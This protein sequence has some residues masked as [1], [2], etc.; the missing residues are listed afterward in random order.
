MKMVLGLVGEKGGGKG[1]FTGL[2]EQIALGD[3]LTVARYRSS[4]VLLETFKIWGIDPTRKNFQTLATAMDHG[5][6]RG[7]LTNVMRRRIQKSSSHIVIFDGVRWRSDAFCVRGFSSHCL[8]YVTADLEIR[9]Q[10]TKQ[11][12]EKVD[13]ED[14]TLQQ[15]IAEEQLPTEVEIPIIGASADVRIDNNGAPEELW[16]KVC[17]FYQERIQPALV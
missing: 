7:T 2:L 12:G 10:R 14:A 17:A 4:D 8:V 5:F 9:Y 1:A 13:E 16:D 3:G 6:G 15:F 11:R